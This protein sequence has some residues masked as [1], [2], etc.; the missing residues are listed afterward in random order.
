M[1]LGYTPTAAPQA[2]AAQLSAPFSPAQRWDA[3]MTRTPMDP[4]IGGVAGA[5]AS[6]PF[7]Q[8]FYGGRPW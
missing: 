1:A 7:G 8:Y 6:F 5:P 2:G 3:A 4:R